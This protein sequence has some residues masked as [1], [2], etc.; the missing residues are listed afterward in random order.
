MEAKR[1]SPSILFLDEFDALAMK[2][3]SAE[4]VGARRVL[5]EL[6][7]QLTSIQASDRITIIASTNRVSDLD[8]AVVRRFQKMVEVPL[9]SMEE[10]ERIIQKGLCGITH[11]LSPEDFHFLSESTQG[12]SGSLLQ[13]SMARLFDGLESHSRSC[14]DARARSLPIAAVQSALDLSVSSHRCTPSSSD[15][16]EMMEGSCDRQMKDSVLDIR[17]VRIGDFEEALA[18]LQIRRSLEGGSHSP[19]FLVS[20]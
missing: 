10:R 14:H 7:I 1:R 17:P 12:W 4:D 11:Q 9:P 15:T 6:L 2:R 20:S 8:P 16:T 5:S 13:V 18:N 3:E 19:L